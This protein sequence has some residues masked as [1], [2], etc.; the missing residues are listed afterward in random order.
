[1]L[2]Q[3]T[4][5]LHDII[6]SVMS[7]DESGW[8]KGAHGVSHERHADVIAAVDSPFPPNIASRR[9]L[10]CIARLPT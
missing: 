1:M 5:T 4:F 2:Q 9:P 3:L 6:L 7:L 8:I 10:L